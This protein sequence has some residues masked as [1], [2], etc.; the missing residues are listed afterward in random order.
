MTKEQLISDALALPLEE[1]VS[2]A[3][4]L[5]ESIDT[6][7]PESDEAIAVREAINRDNELSSGK[8]LGLSHEDVMH[9]ARRA[10]ECD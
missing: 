8:V 5:W 9:K 1:R 3:Q 7:L 2:I 10:L 4:A 6:G